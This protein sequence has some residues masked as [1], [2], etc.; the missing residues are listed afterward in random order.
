MNPEYV[1]LGQRQRKLKDDVKIIEDSLFALSK[2]VMQIQNLVNTEV[3]KIDDNIGKSIDQMEDRMVPQARSSQQFVMTSANNL[4]LLL[5]ESLEQMQ[6]QQQQ[7]QQQ[8]QGG[9]CKKPGK[10]KPGPNAQKLK[11]MQQQLSQQLKDM[12][13]KMENGKKSGQSQKGMSEELARMAAQQEAIRNE[14]NQ[15]NQQE[16]K[17]GK[18]SM[19]NLGQVAE[20]MEQNERDIV[21]KKITEETLKRQQEIVTRLLEAENAQREREQDEQRKA[22]QAKEQFSRN[23]QAFEEY[24]RLKE[25]ETELLKTVPPSLNS[26]YK[27][28]VNS[29]FQ[30]LSK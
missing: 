20:K 17:D 29:Y 5:N 30:N 1:K 28:L 16:N 15:L 11:M 13:G 7:S 22:E 8:K 27:N 3:G 25:K 9:Q 23:P 6:Q 4:A 24:K 19:G 26:Y 18:N 21:N 12:K 14:L 2:R 10:G